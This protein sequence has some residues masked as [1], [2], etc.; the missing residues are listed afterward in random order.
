MVSSPAT[1]RRRAECRW[2][3]ISLR[4]T[5]RHPGGGATTSVD[6]L[7]EVPVVDLVQMTA[8]L[9]QVQQRVPGA[10]EGL[11]DLPADVGGA[12]RHDQIALA[13]HLLY[14]VELRDA[15]GRQVDVVGDRDLGDGTALREPLGELLDRADRDEPPAHEDADPIAHLLHLVEQV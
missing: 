9:P 1:T 8:A 7:M 5:M 14:R 12:H 4:A 11:G 10:D 6:L 13:V 15:P 2:S 3:A